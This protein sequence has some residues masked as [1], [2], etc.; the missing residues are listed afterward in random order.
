MAFA[1]NVVRLSDLSSANNL[2]VVA[3][4]LRPSSLATDRAARCSGPRA[5]VSQMCGTGLV[6]GLRVAP[7]RRNDQVGMGCERAGEHSIIVGVF[8]DAGESATRQHVDQLIE[9]YSAG[10]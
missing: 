2:V 3:C 4:R 5:S 9:Q 8:L 6:S 7:R 1:S 10:L